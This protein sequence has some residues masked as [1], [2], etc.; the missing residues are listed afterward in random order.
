MAME[1]LRYKLPFNII[2]RLTFVVLLCLTSTTQAFYLANVEV[3]KTV[4]KDGSITYSDQP[5]AG[6]V[7]MVLSVP[8]NTFQSTVSSS[9]PPSQVTHKQNIIYTINI[10]NPQPEATIRSNIGEISISASIKP[11]INGFFQLQINEQV[12][13]SATGI[14]TL[15]DMPRGAY[16][17]SVKFIDN[18]GKVIA[19]SKTR[20]M[21]LHQASTLIN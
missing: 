17:Y 21:F 4:H 12:H 18:S 20:N 3:Y 2:K 15:I 16:K 7:E 14:F 9:K 13:E 10:L 19:L 8:T 5:S 6:A 1:K 11:E